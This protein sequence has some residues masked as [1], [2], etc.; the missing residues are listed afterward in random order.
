MTDPW[1]WAMIG[2]GLIGVFAL[3]FGAIY[4]ALCQ[5]VKDVSHDG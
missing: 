5:F 2:A 4:L 3:S 1:L